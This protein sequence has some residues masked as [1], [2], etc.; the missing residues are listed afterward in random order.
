MEANVNIMYNNFNT[1]IDKL[2]YQ[3]NIHLMSYN[4]AILNAK[5]D[6]ITKLLNST[7][8]F[9]LLIV[10]FQYKMK[11]S[12]DWKISI[13]SKIKFNRPIMAIP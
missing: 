2:D 5:P 3:Y 8:S 10:Y 9:V 7:L 13:D 6:S 12:M 4:I 1:S 11:N